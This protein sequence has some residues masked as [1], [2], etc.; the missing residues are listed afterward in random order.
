MIMLDQHF[1]FFFYL[2]VPAPSQKLVE[3]IESSFDSMNAAGHADLGLRVNRRLWVPRAVQ[4]IILDD[5]DLKST[6]N[7][8][9]SKN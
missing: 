1:H 9:I 6:N 4:T 2:T 7:P 3:V 8:K 5:V